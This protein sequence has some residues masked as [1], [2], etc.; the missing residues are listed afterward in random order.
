M[1]NLMITMNYGVEKLENNIKIKISVKEFNV[2]IRP[3]TLKST[4]LL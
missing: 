2:L 4:N 3:L 1:L